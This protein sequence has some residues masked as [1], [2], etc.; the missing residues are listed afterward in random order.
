[1]TPV[2]KAQFKAPASYLS[3]YHPTR[4]DL[5]GEGLRKV[6]KRATRQLNHRA[7]DLN[8]EATCSS[9][10]THAYRPSD[11]RATSVDSR[12][13][14]TVSTPDQAVLKCS[15]AEGLASLAKHGLAASRSYSAIY[16]DFFRLN[17]APACSARLVLGLRPRLEMN[18]L[19][20]I[21]PC[22]SD[23]WGFHTD[24]TSPTPLNPLPSKLSFFPARNL[25]LVVSISF[26]GWPG[27]LSLS[28]LPF[29]SQLIYDHCI[30]DSS[31]K[32]ALRAGCA[33]V[34]SP[35]SVTPFLRGRNLELLMA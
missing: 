28:I 3:L 19:F 13:L 34:S 12:G 5:E 17:V 29:L 25:A 33:L 1:M 15:I 8:I 10:E 23:T 16:R 4:N 6:G 30:C 14:T 20:W 18:S 7:P 22:H 11:G 27:L 26:P 32:P 24:S 21:P 35:T 2:S 9:A 31:L